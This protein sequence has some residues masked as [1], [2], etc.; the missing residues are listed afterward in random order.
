M[1]AEEARA[2]AN[3]AKEDYSILPDVIK[4]IREECSHGGVEIYVNGPFPEKDRDKL[5]ELGYQ[6]FM[7][8]MNWVVSWN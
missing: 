7:R 6:I 8:Q 4:R 2:K 3:K 5:E 1:R